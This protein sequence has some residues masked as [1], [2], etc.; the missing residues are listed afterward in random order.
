MSDNILSCKVIVVGVAGVGKTS[1][2]GRFVTKQ[3]NP[4]ICATHGCDF[5]T[6]T[7]KVKDPYEDDSPP[8]PY[9][10][11]SV[12]E[13][14]EDATSL[15]AAGDE[16]AKINKQEVKLNIW[17]T[18]GQEKYHALTDVFFRGAT[19]A[20]VVFDITDR[21]AFKK[22]IDY[23]L[24]LRKLA[25]EE[26]AIVLVGNKLDLEHKR[27]VPKEVALEFIKENSNFI[28]EYF[29]TSALTGDKVEDV[30]Q[31]LAQASYNVLRFRQKQSE[32]NAT[33]GG[34]TQNKDTTPKSLKWGG[35]NSK[36]TNSSSNSCGC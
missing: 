19:G 29:E 18:A 32:T 25:D 22:V 3:F 34:G 15:T 36:N 35:S 26:I 6:V 5:T 10:Y 21:D 16:E 13:A 24:K 31:Y 14:G 28:Q 1:L 11:N 20:I 17:D 9:R 33:G 27:A 23:V 7:L 8:I 12:D 2:L 4:F 30:F